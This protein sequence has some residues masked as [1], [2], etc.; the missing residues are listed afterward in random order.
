MKLLAEI[1]AVETEQINSLLG[2]DHDRVLTVQFIPMIAR[3]KYT[4]GPRATIC[5]PT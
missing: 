5:D 2:T 3:P 4:S 1:C